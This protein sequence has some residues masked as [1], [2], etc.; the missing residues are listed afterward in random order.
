[1]ETRTTTFSPDI[2][3]GQKDNKS[4][5]LNDIPVDVNEKNPVLKK[6]AAESH[7][8]FF[9]YV[10][11]SG[12][13]KDPNLIVL[14]PSHHYY[15]DDDDLKGV[16]TVL[17]LKQLNHIKDVKDFLHTVYHMLAQNSYFAGSFIDRKNQFGFFPNTNTSQQQ[18]EGTI[19]QFENGIASS[20]PFLNM[21]Y[22][23]LDSRINRNLTKKTVTLLLEDAGLKV[24]DMS[25]INGLTCFCSQKIKI[26]AGYE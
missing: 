10:N 9:D 22:N 19:D 6:L 8:S 18:L 20:I 21:M 25:E 24:L 12:L 7:K 16:T 1:M 5:F 23:I 11:W 17:N 15:Y 13:T 2:V 4:F 14:S 26:S 3:K